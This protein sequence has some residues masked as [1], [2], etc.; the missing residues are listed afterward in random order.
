MKNLLRKFSLGIACLSAPLAMQ[1]E[2]PSGWSVTPAPGS[3]VES[4]TAVTAKN[5][6]G[7]LDPYLNRTLTIGGKP[8]T[9]KTSLSGMKDETITFT[10]DTPVTV[11]GEYEIVIPEATFTYSFYEEDNPEICFTVTVEGEDPEPEPEPGDFEPIDNPDFTIDPAQGE[12]SWIQDLTVEYARS[13]LFPEGNS[14]VAVTLKDEETGQT[15]ATFAK[16]E[17]AGLRDV[18]LS[19]PEPFNTPGTYLVDI[20]AGA[21]F[22]AYDDD[23][24][25]ASFRFRVTGGETPV[26]EPEDVI[27]TP[28]SGTEVTQ[29]TQVLLAFPNMVEIYASGENAGAV[30]VTKDGMPLDVKVTFAYKSGEMD[31]DEI[32]MYFAE[33]LS[34]AGAYTISVPA[35]ALSLG[36]SQFDSRWNRAFTL[37]YSV[38]GVLAPG[39]KIKVEPLTYKVIDGVA[40]TL[41]VTFPAK[42]SEYD[43][44][45]EVPSTVEYDGETWTVTEVG[46]LAF[47]EVTGLKEMTIPSTVTVIGD[48]AFWE[49]S[50]TA[51]TLPESIREIQDDAFTACSRLKSIT[52]PSSVEVWGEDILSE[53]TQL[54]SITLPQTMTAVPKGLAWGD[55]M[56][57]D[58]ALPEGLESIGSFAFAEC[59]ALKDVELP[60]TLKQIDGFA[61]SYCT[62]LEECVI[63]ESVTELGN[64]VFYQAGLKTASLPQGITVVP[65][66][67]Y[68]CC[69]SLEGFRVE[70]WV[71]EIEALAFHWC[72][73]LEDLYLGSSLQTIGKDAFL[74]DTRIAT[75]TS[76]ALTPPVGVAFADEVYSGAVLN[77]PAEAKEAYMAADGWKQFATVK[78]IGEVG[79]ESL[80]AAEQAEYYDMLGRRIADPGKGVFVKRT[81]AGCEKVM[82]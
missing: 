51:I 54:E 17:G 59:T 14:M 24:P 12:V 81:A 11:S 18:V 16:N 63:P 28:A 13:G 37:E 34:E 69:A 45:R 41:S 80:T 43:G 4:I 5:N 74:G 52:L 53:C 55:V 36:V 35:R 39:T 31:I 7:Y 71:T 65:N 19:L 42:E 56:L 1:G 22:D 49:S 44:V 66:A 77:V 6:Q 60:S 8:Y 50:L 10:L 82:K 46:K 3:T 23:W 79:V 68:E 47:S 40:H 67:M 38:K 21:F 26:V 62:G 27:A 9:F 64:G 73:A 58:V 76:M 30:T 32:G 57:E 48:G 72:F 75:V 70:D 25:A 20:P 2:V 33:P 29:L 61:Y 15:V 78:G